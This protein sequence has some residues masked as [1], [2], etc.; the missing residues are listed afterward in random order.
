MAILKT[1]A[2]YTVALKPK[3]CMFH[4]ELAKAHFI[5]LSAHLLYG[6]SVVSF[7]HTQKQT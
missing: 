2:V 5:S 6:P 3:C 7:A 1:P 4:R